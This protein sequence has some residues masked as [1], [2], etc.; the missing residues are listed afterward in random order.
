[1]GAHALPLP[2]PQA[3]S[4]KAEAQKA[5]GTCPG[6]L[7]SVLVSETLPTSRRGSR[8][9]MNKTQQTSKQTKPRK[10]EAISEEERR[11]LETTEEH[12]T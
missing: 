1:M 8:R 3:T 11:V 9:Q 2:D 4:G 7:T 6:E 10:H 5:E 12:L